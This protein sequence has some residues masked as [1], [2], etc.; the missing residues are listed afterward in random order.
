VIA[1][2]DYGAG[3]LTSVKRALDYLGISGRLVSTGQGLRSALTETA[4]RIIFPGVGHARAAMATLKER[5][6]DAALREAFELGTPILGICLG[7]QIVLSHSEEGDTPCLDLIP[8]SCPRFR[9]TDRALKIPHMGWNEVVVTQSHPILRDV[10]RGD[11]FY[12]VHSYYPLPSDA[13]H[14]FAHCEY[15]LTF[16][17]AIGHRNLFA[18]QF[19]PEKSGRTG[20]DLLRNFCE[21][22]GRSQEACRAE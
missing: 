3:N 22:D 1:I 14:V 17:A 5:R 21:W 13:S 11:E 10:K 20:L 18:T 9:L 19:H 8:G 15:G 4:R 2:V 12:F 16:P 6:L 7:A